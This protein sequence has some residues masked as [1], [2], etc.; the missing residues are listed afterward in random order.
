VDDWRGLAAECGHFGTSTGF[1]F[2]QPETLSAA[3][4]S[5]TALSNQA[6]LLMTSNPIKIEI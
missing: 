4:R 6:L 1:D 5:V 3:L 2:A